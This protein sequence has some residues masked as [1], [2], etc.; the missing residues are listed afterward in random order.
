MYN[1]QKNGL[2]IS[3]EGIGWCT[4]GECSKHFPFLVLKCLN[5]VQSLDDVTVPITGTAMLG[6][7]SGSARP[8]DVDHMLG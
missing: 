6:V 1:T 8:I 7:G 3:F 5:Y 2:K 4:A